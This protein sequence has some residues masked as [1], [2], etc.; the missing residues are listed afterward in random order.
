MRLHSFM[1]FNESKMTSK[2][3]FLEFDMSLDTHGLTDTH[4]IFMG[5]Y[6]TEQAMSR[7][8]EQKLPGTQVDCFSYSDIYRTKNGFYIN[9]TNLSEYGFVFFGLISKKTTLV[10]LLIS[11]LDRQKVPHMSYG[12]YSEQDNKAYEFDLIESLG[13]PYIPSVLTI[14]LNQNIL[15]EI[16]EFKYPVI[17]KDVSHCSY[18]TCQ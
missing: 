3:L 10:K 17:V 2:V 11:Y 8:I 18:G 7:K 13:Y 15:D 4:N 6:N 9:G 14:R 16:K 1:K 12:T 5:A